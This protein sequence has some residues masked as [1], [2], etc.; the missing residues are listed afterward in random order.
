[1]ICAQAQHLHLATT[2]SKADQNCWEAARAVETRLNGR[3]AR[4]GL[5]LN[6]K[7]G[8]PSFPVAKF[9]FYLPKRTRPLEN[10][11]RDTRTLATP[12][13]RN[14][15][16]PIFSVSRLTASRTSNRRV[17]RLGRSLI[18]VLNTVNGLRSAG[19]M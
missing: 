10:M 8:T 6:Y 17:D 2:Q 7:N 1:M 11:I 16:S 3:G 15:G 14:S 5:R 9:S 19:I 18:D 12:L 4:P 13:P